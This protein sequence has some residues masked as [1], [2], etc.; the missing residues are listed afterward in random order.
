MDEKNIYWNAM[1]V[2]WF[3]ESLDKKV[4]PKTAAKDYSV[5]YTSNGAW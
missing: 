2:K 5:K 3:C 4:D 1:S